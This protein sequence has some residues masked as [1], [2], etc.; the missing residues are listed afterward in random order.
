MRAFQPLAGLRVLDFSHVIAGPLAS[1]YLAQL[2]ASVTKVE[3]PDGD[4]MR[5]GRGLPAF[6][7][8]NAGKDCIRLDLNDEA[9]RATALTLAGQA[10]V[11]LDSLRPGVLDRFG[12]GATELRQTHPRLI[13]CAI[14][15]FGRRGPWAERPAY[16]HVVQAATGMTLMAGG[17]TDAPIKT[18]FPVVDSAAGIIAALAILATLR[19]R[20]ATGHGR[21]IDVAMSAAAM[22]LMYPMACDALTRGTT[23][24]RVGNQ[25]YSGSPAADIFQARDGWLALGANTPRQFVALL[26]VLGLATLAVD[27]ALFETPLSAS[28]PAQFLRSKDPV[29]LRVALVNA[30]LE[31]DADE[32]ECACARAGVPAARVRTIAEFATDA[33]TVDGLGT[34][35]LAQDDIQITSPGLG[36]RIS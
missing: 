1:F 20:D 7:A 14:S 19:E 34:V 12:L 2:G 26:Q 29:A 23:P 4:I 11:L 9:D 35:R 32:L 22:Q 31:R 18:G 3:S 17:E 21:F 15:G 33:V 30:V 24:A 10:D 13:Y 25:G 5:K 27:P 16:D 8:L 28:T 36:F 6:I